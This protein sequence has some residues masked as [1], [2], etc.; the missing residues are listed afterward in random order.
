MKVAKAAGE[1][2]MSDLTG[3]WRADDEAIY[4]LRQ[5]GNTLWW[6]G[7]S[8]DPHLGANA[9]H[10]GLRFTNVFQGRISGDLVSGD[11]ADVPRGAGV[12][13]TAG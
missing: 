3:T 4:Y 13:R 1:R 10:R 6:A 8:P 9:F 11:W 12:A 7:M 5:V 2:I